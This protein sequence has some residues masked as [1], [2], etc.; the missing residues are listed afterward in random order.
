MWPL[1]HGPFFYVIIDDKW[2]V[3]LQTGRWGV[4]FLGTS[5]DAEWRLLTL[6]DNIVLSRVLLGFMLSF[7][8]A[9]TF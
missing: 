9:M 3:L 7:C 4:G 5:S 8:A 6:V 1:V 2:E